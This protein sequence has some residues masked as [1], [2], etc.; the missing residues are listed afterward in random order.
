[1]TE[2]PRRRSSSAVRRPMAPDPTTSARDVIVDVD[3]EVAV[4]VDLYG[5]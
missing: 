3:I 5:C 1:M 2:T 4:D